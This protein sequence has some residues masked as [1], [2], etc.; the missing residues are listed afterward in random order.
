MKDY[1]D[2]L[3]KDLNLH[4]ESISCQFQDCR[5]KAFSIFQIMVGGI[6]LVCTEYNV[7]TQ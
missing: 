6:S 3:W 1:S 2:L 7:N 5:E 4:S